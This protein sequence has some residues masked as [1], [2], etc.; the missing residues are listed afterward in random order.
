MRPNPRQILA[1][2]DAAASGRVELP[3]SPELY[4]GAGEPRLV[5]FV[6]DGDEHPR[7]SVGE[8]LNLLLEQAVRKLSS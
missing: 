4:D 3:L 2:L 6:A 5:L 1:A 8:Q 7:Q